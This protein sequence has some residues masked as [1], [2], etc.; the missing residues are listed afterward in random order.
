M[1][2]A[3][4][5]FGP[6]AA[7]AGSRRVEVWVE[8]EE[9]AVGVVRERLGKL[10]PGLEKY[11]AVSRFAVNQEFVGEEGVIREGDEVALIGAVSGG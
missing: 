10:V 11:L 9:A 3:V 5:L 7:A 2:V 4:L 8:G 1:T 6:L